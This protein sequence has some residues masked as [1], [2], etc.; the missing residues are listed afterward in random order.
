MSD[1]ATALD[2][3]RPLL[4]TRQVREFTDQPLTDDELGALAD[5]A[6]WTGWED[7][8]NKE[9]GIHVGDLPTTA[10]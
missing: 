3:V 5:V 2:R 4:R 6:R 7:P 1:P 9:C 8:A 10:K